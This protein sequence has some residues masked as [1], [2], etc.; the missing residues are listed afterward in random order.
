MLKLEIYVIRQQ[1]YVYTLRKDQYANR[2]VVLV[3]KEIKDLYSKRANERLTCRPR[4]C[5]KENNQQSVTKPSKSIRFPFL[6]FACS[7]YLFSTCCQRISFHQKLKCG[8][9]KN[10]YT[11]ENFVP[12]NSFTLILFFLWIK[13]INYVFTYLEKHI[14]FFKRWLFKDWKS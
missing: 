13:Q 12:K 14:S 11:K 1:S 9:I 6:Y 4:E 8:S 5:R 2:M 3:T 10:I 7:S